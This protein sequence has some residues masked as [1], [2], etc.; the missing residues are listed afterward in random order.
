M[1]S[2]DSGFISCSRGK[3]INLRRKLCKIQ[4][5]ML[6]LA[7][8]YQTDDYKDPRIRKKYHEIILIEFVLDSWTE[9]YKQDSQ[10]FW[11]GYDLKNGI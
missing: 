7:C 8:Y 2:S 3:I 4:K 9:R 10:L 11:Q 1:E 6:E 5:E